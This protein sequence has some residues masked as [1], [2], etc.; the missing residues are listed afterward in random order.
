MLHISARNIWRLSDTQPFCGLHPKIHMGSN[1][2]CESDQLVSLDMGKFRRFEE[3]SVKKI[4]RFISGGSE[5]PAGVAIIQSGVIG[6][7]FTISDHRVISIF[8]D[9]SDDGI[10]VDA[11]FNPDSN[12]VTLQRIKADATPAQIA[13][14]DHLE[15]ASGSLLRPASSSG[16]DL[17]GAEDC[18]NCIL[19]KCGDCGG[20]T[21]YLP[22]WPATLTCLTACA[23]VCIVRKCFGK[24]T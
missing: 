6:I 3:K 24:C 18:V 19:D 8:D 13:T 7:A 5:E 14:F 1:C 12:S 22:A 11:A 20:C 10:T 4:V 15:T 9:G 2:G 17:M 16:D 23:G 21:I